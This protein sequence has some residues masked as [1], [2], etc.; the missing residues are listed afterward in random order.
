MFSKFTNC[1]LLEQEKFK[2]QGSHTHLCFFSFS[3]KFKIWYVK[4]GIKIMFVFAPRVLP[5]VLDSDEV[6]Y[7]TTYTFLPVT[8]VA[9]IHLWAGV[10]DVGGGGGWGSTSSCLMHPKMKEGN[11]GRR[12]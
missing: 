6:R 7:S 2:T 9:I 4:Y 3:V 5:S 12:L 10:G 1:I 8:L 11:M